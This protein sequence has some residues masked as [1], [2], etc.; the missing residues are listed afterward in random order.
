MEI[1]PDAYQDKKRFPNGAYC[2]ERDWILMRSYSGTRFK[3]HG[4]E[5]RLIN[6]DSVEAVIDDPRGII[7]A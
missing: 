7:K 6:D 5:F 1:G 4:K 3:I 2:K